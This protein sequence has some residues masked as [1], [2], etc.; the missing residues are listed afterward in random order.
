MQIRRER[1][2]IL[3]EV[4]AEVRDALMAGLVGCQK[5]VLFE[6]DRDGLSCGHTPEFIEVTVQ[7]DRPLCG[8]TL[9]VRLTKV[10]AQ[11]FFGELID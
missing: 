9:D 10:T 2:H 5:S 4:Q 7:S 3:Q 1:V 8:K 6:T 11:G